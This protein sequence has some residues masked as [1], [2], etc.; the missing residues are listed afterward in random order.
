MS[1]DDQNVGVNNPETAPEE[2]HEYEITD[3]DHINAR[4][5]KS[6]QSNPLPIAS[7]NEDPSDEDPEGEWS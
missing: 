1:A 4:M 6:L 7:T 3:T 5:L 2:G